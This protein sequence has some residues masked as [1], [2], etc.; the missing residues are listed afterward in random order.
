[1]CLTPNHLRAQKK[2]QTHSN[3]IKI[4]TTTSRRASQLCKKQQ[5]LT[6]SNTFL[7]TKPKQSPINA[8]HI[9]PKTHNHTIEIERRG[10]I[11]IT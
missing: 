6:I 9:N 1:M 11:A 10:E 2:A 3:L 8:L 4:H 7:L 5:H